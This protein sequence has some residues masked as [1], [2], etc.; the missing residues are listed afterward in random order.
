MEFAPDLD[1][2]PAEVLAAL[3]AMSVGKAH[4]SDLILDSPVGT[5]SEVPLFSE[6]WLNSSHMNSET[7]IANAHW[8][9]RPFE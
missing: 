5:M 8:K 7:P 3:G 9:T 2:N 4:S 1:L 6:D